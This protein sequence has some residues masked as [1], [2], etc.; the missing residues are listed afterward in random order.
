MRPPIGA[1]TGT[2]ASGS[3][4]GQCVTGG[5]STQEAFLVGIIARLVPIKRHEIVSNHTRA[6]Q[7]RPVCV[8]E[9]G[10]WQQNWRIWHENEDQPPLCIPDSADQRVCMPH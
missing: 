7:Y 10:N 9:M 1:G 5:T 3:A 8:V 6:E 4:H 2:L